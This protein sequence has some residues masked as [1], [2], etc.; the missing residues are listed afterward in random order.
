MAYNIAN[1]AMTEP[2]H[3]NEKADRSSSI[4]S[5]VVSTRSGGVAFEDYLHFAALQRLEEDG[6][7][8]KAASE[9]NWFQRLS[10]HKG[11]NVNVDVQN[12]KSY[13]MTEYEEDQARAS[14][15]LRL[16][17]W[18]SVFY[19]ITTDILGPFNAP[20]A[21]SQVGWVPGASF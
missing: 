18:S 5:P 9:P 16:A 14:K 10:S 6:G 2:I 1:V 11:P 4:D 12:A 7:I 20:F 17:S 3:I 8:E 19:L 15:A 13:P 21:I